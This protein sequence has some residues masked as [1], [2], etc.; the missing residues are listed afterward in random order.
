MEER[1]RSLVAITGILTI[2]VPLAS[3]QSPALDDQEVTKKWLKI[4]TIT[5]GEAE[6]D[7]ISHLEGHGMSK[8]GAIKLA[9]YVQRATADFSAW[10]SGYKGRV[11]AQAEQL[12]EGG[13][14]AL[15]QFF[16]Q[17]HATSA[18]MRRGY[19]HEAQKLLTEADLER[20]DH[21]LTDGQHGPKL[22]L[23]SGQPN[24]VILARNGQLTVEG[25]LKRNGCETSTETNNE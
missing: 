12:R 8:E 7:R 21:L 19:L 23:L 20:L 18:A 5:S 22:T 3:A 14:E 15:A 9:A 25:V 2:L 16:E 1:M 13:Q 10:A 17:S 4:Q 6:S 24:T 11:C